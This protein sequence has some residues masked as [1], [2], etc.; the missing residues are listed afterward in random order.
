MSSDQGMSRIR[1]ISLY[2]CA[3]KE[4]ENEDGTIDLEIRSVPEEIRSGTARSREARSDAL[5]K[6]FDDL[7]PCYGR[8]VYY[9]YKCS[10]G[11]CDEPCCHY[12][13]SYW[14]STIHHCDCMDPD[15]C[16]E[17]QNPEE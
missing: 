16:K 4:V 9:V 15:A 8:Y 17:A 11:S 6:R 3:L 5:K 14:G 13:T 1:S 10:R 7:D 12:T 2:G